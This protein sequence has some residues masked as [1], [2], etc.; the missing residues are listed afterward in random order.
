MKKTKKEVLLIKSKDDR[1]EKSLIMKR[2]LL[3]SK[4]GKG[5]NALIAYLLEMGDYQVTSTQS[6]ENGR[7][8]FLADEYD[9]ILINTPLEDKI[10][11]E[12]VAVVSSRTASGVIIFI[13]NSQVDSVSEKME[14]AGV[15]VVGKPLVKGMLVQAVHFSQVVKQR[16]IVLQR[17]NE[18]LA[19]R[20]DAVKTVNKAKWVL[21]KYLNMSE[22][23]AHRYIERQAM[24]RRMSKGEVARRILKTY[25]N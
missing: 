14:K 6:G 11:Y 4:K 22:E 1:P 7:K 17:E 9:L 19:G 25:R 23:Q 2:V 18:R 15:M 13:K 3:L 16:I 12:T 5:K 10:G 24:E 21:V 8:L 20:L